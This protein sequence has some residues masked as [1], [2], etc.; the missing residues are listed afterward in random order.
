MQSDEVPSYSGRKSFPWRRVTPCGGGCGGL[1]CAKPNAR[2]EC[3][4][5]VAK[6]GGVCAGLEKIRPR[7][8]LKSINR[9]FLFH[10]AAS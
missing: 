5:V 3:G 7:L 6:I 4:G 1:K 10:C 8:F 2:N 9:R